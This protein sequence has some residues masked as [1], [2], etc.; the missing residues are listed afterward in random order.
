MWGWALAGE[1][2]APWAACGFVPRAPSRG[3]KVALAGSTDRDERNQRLPFKAQREKESL[4]SQNHRITESQNG[5]GWK[6]PL[7]VI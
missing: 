7:C 1:A 2:S 5:R 3:K 6:G 4:I